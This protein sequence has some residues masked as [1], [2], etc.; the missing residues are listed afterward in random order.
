ML[1]FA[2]WKLIRVTITSNKQFLPQVCIPASPG[3]GYLVYFT[4]SSQVNCSKSS[5][6]TKETSYWVFRRLM[7]ILY[8]RNLDPSLILVCNFLCFTSTITDPITGFTQSVFTCVIR[9]RLITEDSCSLSIFPE[10][11]QKKTL[12]TSNI[13][14]IDINHNTAHLS[15]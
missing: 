1:S 15:D 10:C 11:R 3:T 9:K 13:Q 4:L 5:V 8:P 12:N 7:K 2:T 14:N 6:K